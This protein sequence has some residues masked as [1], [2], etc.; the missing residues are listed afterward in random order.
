MD[1]FELL[2][3]SQKYVAHLWQMTIDYATSTIKL[4]DSLYTENTQKELS[5]LRMIT[6]LGVI[7]GFFGMN[8][9]FPWEDRWSDIFSSSL[10]VLGVMAILAA[11]GYSIIKIRIY[12]RKFKIQDVEY[13][14][15]KDAES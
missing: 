8:I 12:N 2:T 7:T 15:E 6:I 14:S 11:I 1:R 5:A 4:L 3:A 13:F 9:A 10:M